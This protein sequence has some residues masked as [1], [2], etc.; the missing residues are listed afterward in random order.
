MKKRLLLVLMLLVTTLTA[1]TLGLSLYAYGAQ[2]QAMDSMM[3]S[4]VLD[5]AEN[6]TDSLAVSGGHMMGRGHRMMGMRMMQ[7]RMLSTN[8]ALPGAESGG[9][10]FL[11]PDRS[12]LS[13]SPGAEKLLSLWKGGL[14]DAEPSEV[15]DA[16]GR[17]YYMAARKLQ[18]S[19]EEITV[20]AAVSKSRLLAPVLSAWNFWLLSI[21][22]SS[23]AVLGGMALLWGYLVLPLR[24]IAEG[25][26]KMRWGKE[27][28]R[29]PQGELFEL[30]ALTNVIGALA[31]EAVAKEELKVRYV[32]DLV[33]VQESAG[34]RLARELHDGPLQSVIAGIK[35]M[36]LAQDA[37]DRNPAPEVRTHLDA[38]ESIC[39]DAAD[40]IRDYCEELSPSWLK[41]GLSSALFE[42]ADRLARAHGVAVELELDER[43]AATEER[44]LALVRILQEAVSN[45]IRH[46]GAASIRVTLRKEN[47]HVTF[48]VE[49]N[50]GGFAADGLTDETDFERLRTTGHR[51]LANMNE[52]VQ[53]L[54][55]SL[56]IESA[57]GQGCKIK[58]E[59]RA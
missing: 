19:P 23:S 31:D 33:R 53:M 7:L 10:L 43:I 51:G 40:E 18:G 46:G 48:T 32:A 56:K 52:R 11:G 15:R 9:I 4:Y 20:L 44:S 45:S 30:R 59:F 49:D 5:L 37:A 34:K 50:G 22:V 26:G 47:E 54:R 42:N 39:R 27:R 35:R 55:G 1:A 3:R 12:I 58:V 14:D 57:P 38:A 16:E 36:Q 25:I 29:F 21:I 24:R 41:L 6:F 17:V 8:P 28:P 2:K 13:A